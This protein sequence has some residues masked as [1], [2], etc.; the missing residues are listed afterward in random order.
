[1]VQPLLDASAMMKRLALALAL[2]ACADPD[3]VPQT[4]LAHAQV[5]FQVTFLGDLEGANPNEFSVDL[6]KYGAD[7]ALNAAKVTD[8][9]RFGSDITVSAGSVGGTTGSD[10]G[11]DDGDAGF[12]TNCE[13]PSFTIDLAPP[14]PHVDLALADHSATLHV[15][16][17]SDGKGFYTVTQCDAASCDLVQ[18]P[19]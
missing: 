13:L 9:L 17:D 12:E 5:A 1:M 15:V 2:T 7:P 14:P 3:T 10:G 6:S 11:F 8:C 18:P 16:L 4:D 19:H